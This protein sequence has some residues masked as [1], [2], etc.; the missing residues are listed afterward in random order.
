[1]PKIFSLNT[2]VLLSTVFF[3][4]ISQNGCKD[5][6]IKDKSLVNGPDDLLNLDF[7]DTFT[8][9]SKTVTEDPY[10]SDG[11]SYGVVGSMGD[12]IFGKTVCGF[13][14]QY[15][16]TQN[17]TLFGTNPEIDSCVFCLVAQDKYGK[18]DVPTNIAIYELAEGLGPGITTGIYKTNESF[19]VIGSPIGLASNSIINIDDSVSVLGEMLAPQLRVKLSNAFGQRILNSDSTTLANNDNFINIFKGVYITSQGPIGNG[20]VY[21]LLAASKITLYYHNSS[22][23]SLKVDF[24][25]TSSSVRVNHY[26]HVYSPN[27]QLAKLSAASSDSI[28]YVQSG[29]GVKTKITFPFISNFPK[30]IA[31]NKA[32]LII[33]KWDGDIYGSDSIYPAPSLITVQKINTIGGAENFSDFDRNGLAT[34]KVV[35]DAN[36]SRT[37]YSFNV[38]QHMQ[39]VISGAYPNNG[40]YISVSSMAN[41]ERLVLANFPLDSRYKMKLK[42]TYTKTL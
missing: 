21:P 27:I 8:V 15:R 6:T 38:T 5:P 11:S 36:G 33:T 32:E 14:V 24:P 31:I 18:N 34:S 16:L 39:Q 22:S 26:D 40:F 42:I 19:G 41:A 3:F 4:L 35:T 1:M 9:W 25:I 17:G 12:P 20:V 13:Y 28:I 23:D 30:G 2:V 7:V 37:V 10:V 29:A